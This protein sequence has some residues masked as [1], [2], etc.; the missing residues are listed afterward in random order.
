MFFQHLNRV[1]VA[2]AM[3]G[4]L[5]RL[6]AER[7]TEEFKAELDSGFR[8]LRRERSRRSQGPDAPGARA[9]KDR[10]MQI[11]RSSTVTVKGPGDW[12]TGDVYLDAV[13]DAPVPARVRANMVHFTPAS[14]TAWHRHP[15]GQTIFVTEGVGLCQRRGGR[16]EVIRP[17][18]R[19]FFAPGEEHWHGAAPDRLMS[20]IAINEV[21]DDQFAS[22]GDHV[23]EAEY[24]GA[25]APETAARPR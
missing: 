12:F 1:Q 21:D 8:M 2:V 5:E 4:M 11:T 25:R 7:S 15:L 18:D 20:H 23:S 14:R 10:D 16:I 19:V 24:A 6:H 13:A 9:R 17:G 22:F 3:L